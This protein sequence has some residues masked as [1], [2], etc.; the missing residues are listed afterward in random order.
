MMQNT[1]N[2]TETLAGTYLRVLS[3]SYL[4]NTNIDRI[5][6]VIKNICILVILW[7]KLSLALEGLTNYAYTGEKQPNNFN[8]IL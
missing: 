7:T 3:E 5:Q 8:D 4:I 6:M 2:L 1:R